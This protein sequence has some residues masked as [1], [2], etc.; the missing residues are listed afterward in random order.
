MDRKVKFDRKLIFFIFVFQAYHFWLELSWFYY[1][2]KIQCDDSLHVHC[3]DLNKLHSPT[4]TPPPLL[5][6]GLNFNKSIY[7]IFSLKYIQCLVQV[8]SDILSVHNSGY[9][10]WTAT[11][12]IWFFIL[13][14]HFHNNW[15]LQIDMY[16]V[17]IWP[18]IGS[19]TWNENNFDSLWL[20]LLYWK[21]KL[22]FLLFNCWCQNYQNISDTNY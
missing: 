7:S 14:L 13:K 1:F 20:C 6:K 18:G 3:W 11:I 10:C 19:P 12:A 8:W 15:A 22:C 4:S 5:L 2:W 17:L 9:L 21:A 16:I